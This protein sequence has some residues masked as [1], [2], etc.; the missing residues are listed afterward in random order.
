LGAAEN[1]KGLAID[2]QF[3][4]KSLIDTDWSLILAEPVFCKVRG[5]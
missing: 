4:G 1:N 5:Y 2:K 3:N